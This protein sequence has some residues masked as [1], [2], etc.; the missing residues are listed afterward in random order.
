MARPGSIPPPRGGRCL[1]PGPRDAVGP[2]S[3]Q[4]HR[5]GLFRAAA[6]E[7][8]HRACGAARRAERHASCIAASSSREWGDTSRVDM[9]FSVA[10][11]YLGLLAGIAVD[12]GLIGDLDEPVGAARRGRRLRLAAQR[13]DDMAPPA[14]ADLGMGGHAVGQARP[15]RPQPRCSASKGAGKKGTPRTLQAP[16]TLLGIQRRPR[17]PPEPR[18]PPPV[19]PPAAGRLPRRA[20]CAP[21]G[22]SGGLAMARLPQFLSSRSTASA[23][24][25]CRAADIGAAASSSMPAIRPGSVS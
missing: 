1:R 5:Q 20:S 18:P 11:S 10:K 21:I 12:R 3:R 8:D 17:Q 23:C 9:T 14:A 25:R 13:R 2:R 15:R 19:P 24:H 16:G 22:A 6:L 7:R 4:R